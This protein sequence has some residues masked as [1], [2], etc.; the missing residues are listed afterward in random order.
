MRSLHSRRNVI[1][2]LAALPMGVAALGPRRPAIAA[3]GHVRLGILNFDPAT[4]AVYAQAAGLFADAGLDVSIEVI[5]SGSAVAAAIIGGSLDI[6][7]SSL[8]SLLTAHTH[9]IPLTLVAGAVIYD[10]ADPITTGLVVKAG[11]LYQHPADL[12]GKIIAVPALQS[13]MYVNIRR[14]VDQTGGRSETVQFTEL[15]GP[16][17]GPG[18]DAGR[19]DAAGVGLPLLSNLLDSG[20]CRT[21]GD[22]SQGIASR[23]LAAAWISTPGYAQ[24]N[25]ATI[26]AFATALAKATAYSNAHPRETAPI[27]AKYTGVDAA[28]IARGP[29]SHYFSGLEPR[30]IQPV[31]D[32]SAKYQVIPKSFPAQDIIA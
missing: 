30:D 14:W 6:G 17:I 5:P 8:F 18:L 13:E 21:L 15:N 28:A 7:L 10:K 31:I 19:I 16:G 23:Y 4:P 1:A 22:P 11:A 25:S 3:E 32:A 12:G 24:K 29:R 9:S 20:L 26:R 2:G 27:L